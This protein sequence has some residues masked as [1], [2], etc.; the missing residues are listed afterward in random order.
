MVEPGLHDALA[1]VEGVSFDH[2][3]VAAPRLRDLLPT[4]SD[5]LGGKLVQGGD[6]ESVGY[7]AMQLHFVAGSKIEL[8]EPLS[9]SRFFDSFFRTRAT[10]VHHLTFKVEDIGQALAV[11]ESHGYAAFAPNL[12]NEEWREVFIHPKEAR[13]VVIQLAQS[14]TVFMGPPELSIELILDGRG[15]R[16][17]GVP[18]P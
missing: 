3:A 4:Y 12:E 1:H 7:R 8:M 9:G 11:M 5:L 18:S 13:G 10:G 15:E 2:A 6:N 16:G 17:N 14:E